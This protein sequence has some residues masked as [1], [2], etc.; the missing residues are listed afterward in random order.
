MM[1]LIE[2]MYKD[3]TM[4]VCGTTKITYQG[5]EIDMGAKWERLTMVEAVKKYAGV[6]YND[7]KTD[8]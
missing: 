2:N 6:D 8:E 7:W 1:N 4:K 3:I 5:V